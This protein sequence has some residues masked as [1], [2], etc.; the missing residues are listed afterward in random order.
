[1]AQCH[2]GFLQR[3]AV[4]EH[5]AFGQ[6]HGLAGKAHDALEQRLACGAGVVKKDHIASLGGLESISASVDTETLAVVVGR[7][8]AIALYPV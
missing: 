1:V 6:A 4:D 7:G 8:H 3:R 5:P 2:V